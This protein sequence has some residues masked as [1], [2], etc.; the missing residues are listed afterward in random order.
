MPRSISERLKRKTWRDIIEGIGK[1]LFYIYPLKV[2]SPPFNLCVLAVL[3]V[4]SPIRHVKIG[5]LVTERIGH[6]GINTD[7][8]LRRRQMAGDPDRVVHVF[9]AGRPCNRQLLNMWKRHL[10]IVE[11]QVLYDLVQYSRWLWER[12]PYYNPLD[13]LFNEYTEY[14]KTRTTLSFTPEEKEYGRRE[15]KKMGIDLGKDWY[16]CIYARDSHYL[17]TTYPKGSWGYHDYRNADIDNFKLASEYIAGLSGYVVRIGSVVNKPFN[18]SNAR[19]ID[20]ASKHHSDFMD[21]FIIAHSR[22]VVGNT[23][24]I[25]DLSMVFDVPYLGINCAPMGNVPHGKNGLFIPKKIKDRKTNR[26]ISFDRII[27]ETRDRNDPLWNGRWWSEK[28]YEFIE[29]TEDEILDVV[30]EMVRR[31]EGTFVLSA[32]E[33]ELLERYF[34]LYSSD[35]WAEYIKTPIGVDFLKKNKGLFFN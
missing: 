24:G 12:T 31:A 34:R 22:F 5:F 4:L 18:V 6:L 3:F 1:R 28:G 20:Y 15:L 17:N 30:R 33:S 26:Y 16:I 11:C 27:Q 10:N 13:T 29:N 35:H 19:V 21:I 23:S 14:Q 32:E 9:L 8:F 7:L 2:I 25:C